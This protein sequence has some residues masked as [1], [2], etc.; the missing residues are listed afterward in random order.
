METFNTKEQ[1]VQ[2]LNSVKRN[3]VKIGLVPTMG[4][5]H[6]G[7]LSLIAESKKKCDITVATIFV[8][9]TQFNNADDLL[10]YPKPIKNDRNLLA[11]A[12]CDV[13]FNPETDEMYAPN[14]K[15]DYKVGDLDTVLEGK[16]RPGHYNGVTQIVYKLFKLVEPDIAFFGQKDY[17]QFLVIDKMTK[18]F[19]LKIKLEACAIVREKDG[20]AMSSR[21]IRLN[22]DE[23][24]KA[25]QLYKALNFIKGHY[26]ELPNNELLNN[27]KS[28]FIDDLFDLEYLEI[29]DRETLQPSNNQGNAIALVACSV[30]NT[31]LIDNMMLP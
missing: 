30:G 25:L 13:L 29:A 2:H 31:R 12:G 3:K 15:W 24:Q 4:A 21:N 6:D 16:F 23:R 5:L 20:L 26:G 22:T 17:Q 7:H 11:T 8:N 27:A 9:P 28:F 14:E 19:G 1:L 18:D 10:K